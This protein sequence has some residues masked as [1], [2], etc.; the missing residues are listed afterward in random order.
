MQLMSGKRSSHIRTSQATGSRAWQKGSFK[1]KREGRGWMRAGERRGRE[2]KKIKEGTTRGR[3]G[4]R[5][6]QM[7]GGRNLNTLEPE[8]ARFWSE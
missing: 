7:E 5:E 8:I 6:G 2:E 4:R 3:E 1:H